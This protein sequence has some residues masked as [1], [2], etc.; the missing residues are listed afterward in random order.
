MSSSHSTDANEW[1]ELRVRNLAGAGLHGLLASGWLAASACCGALAETPV[2]APSGMPRIGT[3]DPRFQ[4]YNIEMIEV[5]GG[6]F[7]KPYRAK[8]DARPAPPPRSGSNTPPGT[9]SN[10]YQYRP[11]ID[12]ANTRLRKLG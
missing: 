10:L 5:T 4:S 6:K 7:W 9:N 1:E 3:V 11:P 8:P 12:L 2:I